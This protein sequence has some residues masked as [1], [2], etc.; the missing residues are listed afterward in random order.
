MPIS[1]SVRL[2]KGRHRPCPQRTEGGMS[3]PWQPR[4]LAR[5]SPASATTSGCR[6]ISI[7]LAPVACP[8]S[9]AQTPLARKVS[10]RASSGVPAV[11]VRRPCA[12]S[13]PLQRTTAAMIPPPLCPRMQPSV[14]RPLSCAGRSVAR[15]IFV[16]KRAGVSR[17]AQ[18][19][20]DTFA[21]RTLQARRPDPAQPAAS[22][23]ALTSRQ[24]LA[25]TKTPS[26]A[27]C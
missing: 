9:S 3:S 20:A 14:C 16:R 2:S 24:S 5:A 26:C 11:V 12:P 22:A 10:P 21:N 15:L 7:L 25:S 19:F 1:M 8:V 17:R 23:I 13:A 4:S 18:I 6:P 27:A